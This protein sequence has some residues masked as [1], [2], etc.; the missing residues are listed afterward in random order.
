MRSENA[1]KRT[2]SVLRSHVVDKSYAMIHVLLLDGAG[3]AVACF[4]LLPD[5]AYL[6]MGKSEWFA[7]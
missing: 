2:R 5:I 6:F 1:P 3:R 4:A 7:F